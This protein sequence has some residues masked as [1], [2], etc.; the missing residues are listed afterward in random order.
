[1]TRAQEIAQSSTALARRTFVI[2]SLL[3]TVGSSLGVFAI[4][5]GTVTGL[6]S[7]LVISGLVF[8]SGALAIH[9]FLRRVP[10]QHIATATTVYYSFYLF[11][12]SII[13]VVGKGEHLDL[14]V[15]LLWFFP[16]LVGNNLI[17][18]PRVARLLATVL[19]V[20][21]VAMLCC[22]A[23]PL[24]AAFKLD[25]LILLPVYS[26]S[27]LCYGAMLDLVTR[28]REAY[29]VEQARFESLKA[30][31][32]ILESIS[33]CFISLDSE[34][35][36][37]YVNEGACREFSVASD[38]ALN[39]PLA[40][41]APRFLSHSMLTQLRIASS[42]NSATSFEA[43]NLEQ[44]VWY[45][46]RC[47][48]RSGAMSI[49]FRNTTLSKLAELKIQH[50][51]FH[52]PLTD[53]PNR[54]LLT[55]RL[56]EALDAELRGKSQGAL[57]FIDLDDFKTLNDTMGHV[58]GDFLLQQVALRLASRMGADQLLARVGGDEF[59][60]MISGLSGD[61][62]AAAAE[63]QAV[64]VL[65]LAEFQRPFVLGGYEYVCEPSMG[66]ALFEPTLDTVDALMKRADLA[67]Y[68]AKALGR[69]RMCFFDPEM[70]SEVASRAELQ[71]DLRRALQ[72]REFELHFQPQVDNSGTVIGA[73]ALLRWRHPRRGLVPPAEFIPLAEEAG[74]IFEVG[75][76]V[77][78][79]ACLQLAIWAAHP[80]MKNLIVAVNVSALQILHSHFVDHV[81]EVLR[82]SKADPRKLRLEI[83][84][85][86]AMEKVDETI[87]KMMALKLLGVGFSLDDFGT[88]YSSLSH[89]K[90]LPLEELKIDRSFVSDVLTDV[91]GASITR[92]LVRLGLD[93]NLSVIA[94]GVETESQRELLESQGCVL[95][96]GYL[97]SPALPSSDFESFVAASLQEGDFTKGKL[98]P[99]R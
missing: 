75:R 96:Q 49:Y 21:P 27:Y 4:F 13:A 83:T 50:I 74:L 1:M 71:S 77:L 19:R 47:F 45:E 26:L 67:M 60:V 61:V 42:G 23:G 12:G 70:E 69:N 79:T 37:T 87:A 29:I 15:F 52:D 46:F 31:S 35:N 56:E 22:L 48:P 84:E 90:R 3:A 95:Y 17:N 28:Y 33:D 81:W 78:E 54:F 14:F 63:A 16:L 65:V 2:M 11:S 34:L 92:T 72:N 20:A 99:E 39:L 85:S 51:A 25:I 80:E 43:Q 8:N 93:L 68:R 32:E 94:E 9:L 82:D 73:E 62:L 89:L 24:I 57:L 53:L 59:A 30:Q 36:I 58:A 91:K 76:W 6:E 97:F 64:G 5:H 88:G 86:A 38:R 40:K 66:V 7:A 98:A 10:F 18:S 41:V 55:E 44:D